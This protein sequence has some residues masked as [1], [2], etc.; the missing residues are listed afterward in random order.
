MNKNFDEV[1]YHSILERPYEYRIVGFNFQDNLN[2]FRNL[3]IELTLQK[4]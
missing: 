2:D 3:F 4:I 1:K